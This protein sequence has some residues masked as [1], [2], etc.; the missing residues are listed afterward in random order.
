[1]RIL[2]FAMAPNPIKLRIYCAEKRLQIPFEQIDFNKGE[3]RQPGF[4]QKNPLGTVPIL[5]LDTG[6]YLTESLVIMEYLE[7]LYPEPCMIGDSPLERAFTRQAERFIEWN[8]FYP[9]TQIFF[10]TKPFFSDHQQIPAIANKTRNKLPA[11]LTLLDKA[12]HRNEFVVSDKPT[13]ADCTLFA[14]YIHAKRVD[15]D[16]GSEHASIKQW[17]QRFNQRQSAQSFNF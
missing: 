17:F 5:E 8:I 14:A 13:I 2:D 1:M 3:Q 12:L 6:S 16:L 11:A 7:E 4:L 15:I 9:V 10:H